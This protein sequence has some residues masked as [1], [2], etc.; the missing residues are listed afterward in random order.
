MAAVWGL[1]RQ[2]FGPFQQAVLLKAYAPIGQIWVDVEH[3]EDMAAVNMCP[4]DSG[5]KM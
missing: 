4:P 5:S 1:A 2:L 3:E